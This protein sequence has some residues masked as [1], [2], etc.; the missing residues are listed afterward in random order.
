MKTNRFLLAA[1]IMLALAF[2]FGCSSGSD[3]DKQSSGSGLDSGT[4]SCLVNGVCTLLALDACI[5][6]GGAEVQ[7]CSV[8]SGSVIQQTS[9]SSSVFSSSS[10]K[11]VGGSCDIK[12]YKTVNI[13]GQVWMAENFNC[14]VSGSKKCY[15][16]GGKVHNSNT[17]SY[18]IRLSDI[19]IQANCDTYGKLYDWAT[20][21][22]LP[23][24][25]NRN[26]CSSQINAKHKGICPNGWHIPSDTDWN[27]LIT[28]IDG[29]SKAGKKL[30]ATSGWYNNG[31]GTDE[32]EF[33][34]LPG[35]DCSSGGNFDDVGRKG[36]WWSTTE[37]DA[38][39][40]YGRGMTYDYE[41]VYYYDFSKSRLLSV[42]CLKD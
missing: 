40:A 33:S 28:A 34:A 36:N 29:S 17:G 14:D 11:Y 30:K 31:N 1:S 7:S 21:M 15:G 32:Y 23:S 19:E 39:I 16:E 3:G 24:S 4:V 42:R 37:G 10:F 6:I 27:T 26:E 35:G 5:E 25:C 8:S 22:A 12:D 2:A 20:A 13:G 38:I 41:R 18:D 9:S